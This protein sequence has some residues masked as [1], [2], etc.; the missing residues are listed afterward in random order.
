MEPRFNDPGAWFTCT[1]TLV[2]PTVVVTAG[3]CT[4]GTGTDGEPTSGGSGGNDV[5]IS[6]AEAPEFSIL[7]SSGFV[8]DGNDARYD[9]WSAAL[10]A[11]DKWIRP[12]P[13]P[14][15]SSTRT[16]SSAMTWGCWTLGGQ[17]PVPVEASGTPGDRCLL[18]DQLDVRGDQWRLPRGPGRRPR[19]LAGFGVTP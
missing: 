13:S 2:S 3:H 18:R 10:N 15:P 11:S 14:T 4:F 12:P 16:P 8:P 6:F 19:V 1:G 5:W 9:A 17:L 7:P